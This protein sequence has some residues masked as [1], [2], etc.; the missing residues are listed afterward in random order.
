MNRLR[1]K[2]VGS[3]QFR[4]LAYQKNPTRQLADSFYWIAKCPDMAR[5]GVSL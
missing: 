3:F 1:S 5:S 4:T 2:E